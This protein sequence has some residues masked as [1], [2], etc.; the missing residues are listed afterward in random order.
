MSL[1]EQ[2]VPAENDSS[3]TVRRTPRLRP[4][5]RRRVIVESATACICRHGDFSLSMTEIARDIGVSRNLVYQYFPNKKQLIDAV[6][7]YGSGLLEKSLAETVRQAATPEEACRQMVDGCLD[8]VSNHT[9]ELACI[10]ADEA[11]AAKTRV[12]ARMLADNVGG[13]LVARLAGGPSPLAAASAAAAVEYM[14]GLTHRRAAQIAPERQ[15]IAGLCLNVF[16]CALPSDSPE[17]PCT[18]L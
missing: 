9:R 15:A 2:T 11:L 5:E 18:G 12:H 17:Q 7:E 1:N 3:Q 13:M 10:F 8:F 16:A 4:E 6:F 14:I